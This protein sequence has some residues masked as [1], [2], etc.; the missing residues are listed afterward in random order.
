MSTDQTEKRDSYAIDE[1]NLRRQELVAEAFASATRELLDPLSFPEGADVLDVGCGIGWTTRH[2]RDELPRPA[3]VV[4][5][6]A[7]AD[8]LEVADDRTQHDGAVRP[9]YREGDA[10]D[11]HFG[12]DSFDIVFARYLLT[13]LPNPVRALREFR[14]VCREEGIVVVQ[15]GDFASTGTWPPLSALGRIMDL[16]EAVYDTKMGRKTWGLFREAGIEEPQVRALVPVETKETALGQLS[17][18]TLEAMRDAL[19]KEGVVAE[20]EYDTLLE[21]ARKLS[22]ENRL[23]AAHTV[24]SVW[25]RP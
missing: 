20:D 1:S 23:V 15:E 8:L 13:H 4:G 11:L 25:G 10:E 2:L 16:Y 21:E 5:L 12:E 9:T 19:L 18:L 14:R 7:N 3:R 24:Y 22:D 6:D 17:I